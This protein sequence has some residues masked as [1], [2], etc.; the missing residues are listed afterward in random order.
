MRADGGT[1]KK[2]G[3]NEAYY[4]A[5]APDNRNVPGSE[6]LTRRVIAQAGQT[7]TSVSEWAAPVTFPL[8]TAQ[9]GLHIRSDCRQKR[10]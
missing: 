10:K 5:C 6:T 2:K 7:V 3:K 1:G 4:E 9:L 8:S